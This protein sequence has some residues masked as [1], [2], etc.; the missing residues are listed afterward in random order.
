MNTKSILVALFLSA[1]FVPVST[2]Q[3]SIP[4]PAFKPGE[5]FF[6]RVHLKTDRNIKAKSALV[7]PDIP[8][9]AS[10]D[11]NGLL[12]VEVLSE[13]A[14]GTHFRTWFLALV[15]DIGALQSGKKPNNMQEEHTLAEDKKIECLLQPDGQIVQISGLDQLA[16]EQQSAWRE[17]ATH[18]ADAF[19]LESRPR[20]QGEKWNT[21]EPETSPA[22]ISELFWQSKS[23]YVH[24]QPCAPSRFEQN[25]E[26][27]RTGSQEN[28]AVILTDAKLDQK[29]SHQD[30]TPPDYKLKGLKTRGTAKGN[31]ETILYISR[32]T[33]RLIRATQD[34]KQQMDVI[35]TLA[36]ANS[37]IQYEVLASAKSTVE[38]VTEL[39][40]ILHARSAN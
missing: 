30:S 25:G 6:Y 11:V 36:S 20:K 15:S 17:W 10:V 8:N 27:R 23:Q 9:E 31:N 26:F 13:D 4:T 39:P 40:F 38:L 35:I 24:D 3:K 16:V 37:N 5:I 7:L 19:R 29:S 21:E 22:P 14:S 32:K 12:Q 2:A 18:F 34:A 1:F 28:C 33:G